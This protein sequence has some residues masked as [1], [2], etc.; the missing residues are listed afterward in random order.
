METT[1]H[2]GHSKIMNLWKQGQLGGWGG[3][4]RGA[5]MDTGR[6]KS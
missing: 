4:I 2:T 3:V 1:P 5:M 6:S